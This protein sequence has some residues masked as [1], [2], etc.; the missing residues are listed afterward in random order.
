M[1]GNPIILTS[2]Y[3]AGFKRY[4]NGQKSWDQLYVGGGDCSRAGVPTPGP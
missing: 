1:M 4:S 2:T 3:K